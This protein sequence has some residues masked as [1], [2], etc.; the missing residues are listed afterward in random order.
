M[1]P[2]EYDVYMHSTPELN[3]FNLTRRDRSH[4]CVRLEHADQMADWVLD[5][6]GDWDPDKIAAAMNAEDKNNK[7]VGLKTPLPVVVFYLTATAD[8]DGTIHFFDDIYN[9]DHDLQQML[10][11]GMPYP[12]SPAKINPKLT[13]GETVVAADLLQRHSRC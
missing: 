5:G 2:N 1:F 13:P 8:E 12:Q 6:Q 4:G 3:L 7:T 10:D 9:Y 11:K